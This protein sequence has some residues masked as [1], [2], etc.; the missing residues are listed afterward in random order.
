MEPTPEPSAVF[1]EDLGRVA[2]ET[3]SLWPEFGDKR[4]LISGGTGFFGTWL[5]ST[6]LDADDRL[7]LG[8]RVFLLTRDP[9]RFHLKAPA[10][11]R[12][13]AVTLLPGDVRSFQFPDSSL[14]FVVHAA[15]EASVVMNENSPAELFDVIVSGTRRMLDLAISRG[16]RR[17][18]YVSS[19]AVYGGGESA[20]ESLI[21]ETSLAAPDPLACSS[22]TGEGKR[23]AEFL[24]AC[25][26][27]SSGL[28][29]SIARCF[30]F[31]GPHMPLDAH[32]AAGNFIRDAARGEPIRVKGDG[33]SRRSYLYA[34]DLAVW[35]WTILCKG[36][37]GRAYNVGSERIVSI[38]DL[39]RM[40][41]GLSGGRSRV[42]IEGRSTQAVAP[43]AYAPSTDRCRIE[44]GLRE[45]VPLEE[46]LERTYRWALAEN[47]GRLS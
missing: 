17:L 35:L 11:A 10:L 20:R 18:L 16:A 14:D 21:P 44:L 45:T 28:R 27:K 42:V 32:F 25:A 40:V 36:S 9:A 34:S 12:H 26:S 41:E 1:K 43:S 8:I 39:A 47:Q 6:L 30:A 19:G 23:A 22:A 2:K 31:V 38:A 3:I 15:M 46:A 29:A 37:S 5:L 13:R 33:A 24:C 7:G 4:I